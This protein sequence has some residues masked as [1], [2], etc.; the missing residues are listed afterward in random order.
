MVMMRRMVKPQYFHF[1]MELLDRS[2]FHAYCQLT[3]LGI[4]P[5]RSTRNLHMLVQTQL[6]LFIISVSL[7]VTNSWEDNCQ[8][9]LTDVEIVKDLS[10]ELNGQQVMVNCIGRIR[11]HKCE[12]T[13]ESKVTPSVLHHPGFNKECRCCR[14]SRLVRRRVVLDECFFEGERVPRLSPTADIEGLEGCACFQCA[15]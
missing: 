7:A 8:T 4:T 14:E 13:C 12:G 15:N 1:G 10:I 3:Y 11:V 2:V 9:H 6:I 5:A